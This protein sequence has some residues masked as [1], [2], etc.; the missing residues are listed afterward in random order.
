MLDI[1]ATIGPASDSCATL[2]KM[3]QAGMTIARI[4]TKHANKPTCLHYCRCLK[5]TGAKILF[6]REEPEVYESVWVVNIDGS[7]PHDLTPSMIEARDP[8][9]QGILIE[10]P[11]PVGGEILPQSSSTISLWLITVISTVVATIGIAF[12]KKKLN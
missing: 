11:E 1:I 5:G 2:K 8:D 4:N 12:K 6:D 10:E 3:S 9:W 7:N